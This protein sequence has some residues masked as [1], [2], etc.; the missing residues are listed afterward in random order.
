MEALKQEKQ[1]HVIPILQ[2]FTRLK[3]TRQLAMARKQLKSD[4]LGKRWFDSVQSSIAL[5]CRFNGPVTSTG[6]AD[7]AAGFSIRPAKEQRKIYNL[8]LC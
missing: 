4:P 6:V 1:E 2:E 5:H 7:W 8:P 3:I